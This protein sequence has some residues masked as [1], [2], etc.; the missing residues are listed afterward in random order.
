MPPRRSAVWAV[1]GD[2]TAINDGTTAEPLRNHGGHGGATA[3][4]VVQAPQW[5]RAF[6]VT[7]V[8]IWPRQSIR[9]SCQ[10]GNM[11]VLLNELVF[12]FK[13]S[14]LPKYRVKYYDYIGKWCSGI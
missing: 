10:S 4:Y 14:F 8:L 7:G 9:G 13:I 6:G 11:A 5:H 2:A 1:F 12:V 3:V